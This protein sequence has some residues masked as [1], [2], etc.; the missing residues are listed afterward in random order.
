VASLRSIRLGLARIIAGQRLYAGARNTRTTI[1]FGAGADNSSDQELNSSLRVL[2]ARSRQMVRDS[3]YAKRAK[4]IVVNN[5]IGTGVGMQAQVANTRG[6]LH[7]RANDAIE[8]TWQ[9]WCEPGSCH[10]GGEL[11]FS[12]MERAAIGQVFE[13]GEILIRKHYRTAGDSTVPLV[14]ELIEAERL[15]DQFIEVPGATASGNQVRMGVE[16][17]SFQRPVAYWLRRMHPGDTHTIIGQQSDRFERVPA[18]DIYH[19][20]LID[21]WPQTRGEPWLHSVLRKLDDMNEYTQLEVTAARGSAAYFATIT[22]PTPDGFPS[23]TEEGS[24]KQVIDLEPLTVQQLDPG[25]ALQFHAP[26]RPNASLDPFM[27]AMLREVAAGCG[28]SY[29]SLSRDYSQS[30]YSSS[31]MA[32]LD[33]RDLYKAVQQWWIRSFRQPLHKVWLRQAV[34]AGAISAVPLDQYA[35]DALRYEA[36][37]F[38]PRGWSWID[39]T[40]EV[41]AY[42]EAI[43]AGLT[44]ITDVVAAT[45]GGMDVEDVVRTRRRELDMFDEANIELDTTVPEPP[46]APVAPAAQTAADANPDP[47]A[48]D[49]GD[50]TGDNPAPARLVSIGGSR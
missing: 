26:N 37:L 28:T 19:L 24:Q 8:S 35:N 17:D 29:E 7:L 45:G 10:T 43:K 44:T 13:A 15:A 25:E 12:D 49:G 47:A 40:K 18:S 42:K 5:V 20:R 48:T 39:P 23:A 1:G 6:D 32:L 50:N 9:Q 36:V 27:R 4:Q 21:R 2:R 33:D 34:L 46:A 30:N 14:L 31:R 41:A 16:V 3:A 38:K 11:H 22:T